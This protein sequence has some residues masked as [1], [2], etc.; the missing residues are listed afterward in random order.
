MENTRD[1]LETAIENAWEGYLEA[2][3]EGFKKQAAL[4]KKDAKRLEKL[5]DSGKKQEFP[6]VIIARVVC[7][8]SLTRGS[9]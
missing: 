3:Y 6:E 5:Y 2:K 9:K 4:Y 8:N 7:T 1:Q